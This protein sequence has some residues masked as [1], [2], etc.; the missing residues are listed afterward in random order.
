VSP[1]GAVWAGEARGVSHRRRR[2]ELTEARRVGEDVVFILAALTAKT[3]S[4]DCE[5]MTEN[6]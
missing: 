4:E 2:A 5:A 6:R 1:S 3:V